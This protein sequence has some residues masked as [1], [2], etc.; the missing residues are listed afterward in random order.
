MIQKREISSIILS[1]IAI[2]IFL[3]TQIPEKMGFIGLG[4]HIILTTLF[5]TKGAPLFPLFLLIPA[6]SLV[7]T[8]ISVK[9]T[10]ISSLLCYIHSV[11]LL[12]LH[13]SSFSL[14]ADTTIGG[15]VGKYGASLFL[16]LL[17]P[18]GSLIVIS[19]VLLITSIFMFEFSVFS[20]LNIL[21]QRI[22]S[23]ILSIKLPD[24]SVLKPLIITLFFVK[25]PVI[26]PFT[27]SEKK[28]RKKKEKK[29]SQV[30]PQE[31]FEIPDLPALEEE[32]KPPKKGNKPEKKAATSPPITT[33]DDPSGFQVPPIDLL[34]EGNT[35][36]ESKESLHEYHEEQARVLEMA[37]ESFN[38]DTKVVNITSGPSVT[39]YELKPGEGVKISKI[40]ALTKDIALKLAS[41]DIRIEA[42]I[43]GKALVGIEVPNASVDT[44][45]LRSIM[46]NTDFY[47][48]ESKLTAAIGLTITGESIL[49][50]LAKMPHMLIAGATG[51]GK[52]VCINTIIVSI[53]MRATPDE[54]KFLMIDPKKVE[55]SLYENIPHLIAPVV[56]NPHMAAATLKKWA[57]QEMEN[58]YELFTNTGVKDI[59][60]Y[61][62]YIES[63]PP[64]DTD[65]KTTVEAPDIET[66]E[67]T[68][69]NV[70]DDSFPPPKKLPYIVVIIDELA[71][72]MMVAS[73]DVEQTIC[74]LAQMARATGIHLVIATQRP[75]VNVVTGLIKANVPSRISFYLQSQ[76]DSRTILDMAGAEKL[77][78][79]G[80][81]L[82]SPVGSFKPKR[83]QGVFIGEKEVKNI[84]SWLKEQGKPDY[85]TE[86][87]EIEPLDESS[88]SD[89]DA[90]GDDLYEE[91]KDIVQNSKYA[92]TS[93]LQR[94]LRIGYNRAARLMDELE[95]NG[96]ISSYSG[97]KKSR[98][99]L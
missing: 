83:V 72:L 92:S 87:L 94:K 80:D 58:R 17:G 93:Y 66:T 70:E 12:H 47:D 3:T 77:L 22:T 99:V 75:S 31:P 95:E 74:R 43:P 91:A 33:P 97:E 55:L 71:D 51:S 57:L 45:T 48:K 14:T 16:T 10:A 68:E 8:P 26:E 76:I 63:L 61:N 32:K 39:R 67:T 81:M 28:K 36:T 41:P 46:E 4:I 18:Y 24:T 60:G 90:S 73:Q 20:L 29:P 35:N 34:K 98:E 11:I 23:L 89:D 6:F 62:D 19:G 53:L 37:L 59:K 56:T 84:V 5:G 15:F 78:G 13:Y 86:I 49:L 79:K 82:Y 7:I 52:S 30:N 27:R 40:T 1:V 50:D 44:V 85:D 64:Q 21:K 42:P 88:N 9:R 65:K 69:T 96:V 38:V 2:F 54:V 25:K